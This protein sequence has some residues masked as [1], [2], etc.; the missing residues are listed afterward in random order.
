MITAETPRRSSERTVKEKCSGL[1][2]VS[3]S[4]INGLVVT[5]KISLIVCRRLLMST[6]SISGLPRDV[7]SVSELDHIPSN[8]T[9]SPL[10]SA[11]VFSMMSPDMPECASM[12]RTID[13]LSIRRRK[14]DRRTDGVVPI[15]FNEAFSCVDE[16]PSVYGTSTS[17]PPHWSSVSITR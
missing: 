6:A 4:K 9:C 13:L 3:P 16:M 10:R 11:R 2:P 5:S 7:E 8:S 15:C 17:L 1:P 14:R 12:M